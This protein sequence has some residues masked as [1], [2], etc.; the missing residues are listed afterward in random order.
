MISH[1][2]GF[3]LGAYKQRKQHI[4]NVLL[5]THSPPSSDTVKNF[6]VDRVDKKSFGVCVCLEVVSVGTSEPDG[7]REVVVCQT[8]KHG[9]PERR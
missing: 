4:I 3:I 5:H 9:P 6:R 7:N 2:E 8:V 1:N